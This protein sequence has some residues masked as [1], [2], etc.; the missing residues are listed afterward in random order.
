MVQILLNTRVVDMNSLLECKLKPTI[1]ISTMQRRNVIVVGAGIAGIAAARKLNEDGRFNVKILEAS[2]RIGGRIFS[3][4]IDGIPV[5]LGATYIHGTIDNVIYDLSK[6]YGI[7]EENSDK[8]DDKIDVLASPVLL[9]NGEVVPNEI[10]IKCWGK[11]DELL[12]DMYTS[13]KAPMWASMYEDMYAYL[14]SEYPKRLENDPDTRDVL[15]TPYSNSMFEFFLN[16]QSVFEGQENCKGVTIQND[17]IDLGGNSS[18]EF[19]NGHTF[20][21]LLN[22]LVEDFPKDTICYGRE[23]VSI[24]TESDPIVIKCRSGDQFEA[25]HVII[26]ISLGVL[27]RRCLDEN[28]LPH[29]CSLFIPTLPVEKEEAIRKLGFGEI[30]KIWLQF[31]QEISSKHKFESLMM[32]WL[33]E[34]KKDPIIQE[35]FPWAN[36]MYILDKTSNTNLYEAW[37]H[38]STVS[39]IESVNKEEIREGMSY[40]LGKFLKHP[41]AKPVDVHMHK[42]SSDPLFGGCYTIDLISADTPTSIAALVE[43]VKKNRVLFAGEATHL[44]HFA[45]VHGAYLTGVREADRL[46]KTV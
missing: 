28:L 19:R 9:S 45:T 35:K 32:L 22:K 26:T 30:G 10:V 17:Y 40:I 24:N 34:D 27:K 43:P 6:Q 12:E 1:S 25:D 38:G 7:V 20:S 2:N 46:I 16:K 41:V 44:E 11:F 39:Q 14:V 33:P 21:N 29:E 4:V 13:D 5:E 3:S 15:K 23:V 18:V 42:W 31:E 37:I 36:G 8:D